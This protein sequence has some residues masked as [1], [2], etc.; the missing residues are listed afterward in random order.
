MLRSTSAVTT[1]DDVS[2]KIINQTHNATG[3]YYTF[4]MPANK[5]VSQI[6]LEF[7]RQNFDWRIM[8]EGSQNQEAWFTIAENYRIVAIKND[9][10]DYQFTRVNFP[11]TRYKY[12]R[13]LVKT[14]VAPDLKSAT[15]AVVKTTEGLYQQ[16][17]VQSFKSTTDKKAKQTIV[18]VSLPVAA[19]VSWLKMAVSSTFD[20]YRPV[21]IQYVTDSVQTASGW[22]YSYKTIAH[23]TLSSL[24]NPAFELPQ[25]IAKSLRI[26]ITNHDNEPLTVGSVEVKGAMH[27]LVCRFTQKADYALVYG[28]PNMTAPNYDIAG[29]S[30]KIP[31]RPSPL[32]VGPEQEI[33][34]AVAIQPAAPLFKNKW[35]LCG[36]MGIIIVVLG[37]FSISMIRN[38]DLSGE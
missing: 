9:L 25:T 33:A 20:Y 6:S 18:D 8:V 1:R 13:L 26:V 23:G 24:E 31:T 34:K 3:Y 5:A 15:V 32:T 11:E 35:W 27:E 29:F 37:W 21:T 7:G 10:T 14:S 16:F 22:A 4:E 17:P 12:Y 28:D 38:H 36:I 30:D 2:F 19:P